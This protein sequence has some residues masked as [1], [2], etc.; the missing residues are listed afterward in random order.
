[1][2]SNASFLLISLA[3][4]CRCFFVLPLLAVRTP[5]LASPILLSCAIPYILLQFS[6]CILQLCRSKLRHTIYND[7]ILSKISHTPICMYIYSTLSIINFF[8]LRKKV[9][10]CITLRHGSVSV[11][12]T[13]LELLTILLRQPPNCYSMYYHAWLLF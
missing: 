11:T 4:N 12:Q 13:D 1:M 10:L 7:L 9:L 2:C 3:D 5:V 8:F 6:S